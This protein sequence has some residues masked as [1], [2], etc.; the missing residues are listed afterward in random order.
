[1]RKTII[2]PLSYTIIVYIYTHGRVRRCRLADKV[3]LGTQ[4]V[5]FRLIDKSCFIIVVSII[6][7][8]VINASPLVP[9]M[10]FKTTINYNI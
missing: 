3:F 1:M 5:N 6:F 9:T 7:G 4:N 8:Q 2:V 10:I